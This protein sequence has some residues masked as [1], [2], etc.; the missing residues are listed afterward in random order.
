VAGRNNDATP[1][2]SPANSNGCFF[3]PSRIGPELINCFS[4]TS[5][6]PIKHNRQESDKE[7]KDCTNDDES[8]VIYALNQYFSCSLVVRRNRDK[9]QKTDGSNLG[10]TYFTQE[11]SPYVPPPCF[12][13][14]SCGWL[15]ESVPMTKMFGVFWSTLPRKHYPSVCHRLFWDAFLILKRSHVVGSRSRRLSMGPIRC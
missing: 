14:C 9:G 11:A 4:S 1:R 13:C 3:S 2:R 12:R 5:V 8:C 10:I 6:T 15:Q 7:N